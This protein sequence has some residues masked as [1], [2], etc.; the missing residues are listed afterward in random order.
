[1]MILYLCLSFVVSS[2]NKVNV[3]SVSVEA[4]VTVALQLTRYGHLI[5]GW[6]TIDVYLS[7]L[8]LFVLLCF[9]FYLSL[10]LKGWLKLIRSYAYV[11]DRCFAGQHMV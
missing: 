5:L 1:M 7:I 9:T 10:T 11:I 6:R 2:V 8:S 3:S 4:K